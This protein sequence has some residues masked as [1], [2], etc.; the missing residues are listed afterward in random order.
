LKERVRAFWQENPC[1]T[2]FA[3]VEQGSRR[4]Y[5]AVEEHRYRTEW[6][7][8]EAAGFERAAGLRVL[9]IGC[10][11]GTD[12]ARFARAGA[13]YTGVDLTEAA[14][15]L[16]R[17]RFE[18]EGLAG[19]FRVADAERL[20]FADGSFDLVYSHGVLHHT[21]DAEAAVA[22]VHRVLAPGGRAVVMLYH[23]DSYNYRVNIRV[24]R[25]VGARLLN[26]EAGLGLAHRLTS[27][28]VESLREHA[29]RLRE[30]AGAYLSAGEFLSRNTDGAGNP[31]TRVYSRR[32]ARAL[33]GLFPQVDFAVHFLNKRWLPVLGPLLPR[34]A[35]ARLASRWGWH[36]WIYAS[37]K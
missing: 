1:G 3:G 30:D 2:K 17:R 28:P 35:E 24:L 18:L 36:L 20:E 8:P 25:R 15:G 5:E 23:R 22:E 10:G 4:F 37:K 31:L 34:G 19:E 21:P 13:V 7:I 27:E 32:E 26:T 14:V 9:E 12:G 16:A 11:L 6:H 29:A 33:F